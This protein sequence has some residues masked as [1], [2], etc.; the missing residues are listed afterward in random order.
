MDCREYRDAQQFASDVR[1]MFSN[2]YKYNPPDHD[3]VGMARKLQASSEVYFCLLNIQTALDCDENLFYFLHNRM[4]LSSALPKC[5]MNPIWIIQPWRWLATQHPLP[6][7]PPPPRH[8]LPPPLRVSP[9]VRVKR[10]RVAPA[11]TARK[12]GHIAWLSCRTKCAPKYVLLV[13]RGVFVATNFTWKQ[14]WIEN[15]IFS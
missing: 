12:S 14:N 8:H 13:C 10:V 9:A 2:C 1:L 5:R 11:Q 3:V 7:L 6:H 15:Q 4:C